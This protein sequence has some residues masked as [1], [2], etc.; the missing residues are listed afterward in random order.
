[1]LNPI[2]LDDLQTTLAD[3]G[4]GLPDDHAAVTPAHRAA[5]LCYIYK[6][7]KVLLLRRRQPPFA[8]NWTAPGGKLRPG[9]TPDEAVRREVWEETGLHLAAPRLRLVVLESGPRPLLNWLLYV[10]LA[11]E[12]A[13]EL[14]TSDEGPLEW[15][16]VDELARVGMP[17]VDLIISDYVFSQQTPLWLEVTLDVDEGYS[18]LK[19]MP[20]RSL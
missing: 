8:G 5:A 10:Y 9:E 14:R 20:L 17:D 13:G 3:H 12:F 6:D 7:G 15:T 4:L 18:D 19:T 16:P 2:Q 1:M 11:D